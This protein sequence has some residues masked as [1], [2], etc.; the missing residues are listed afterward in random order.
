MSYH[1]LD[2]N[3]V[4]RFVRQN[5][6]VGVLVSVWFQSWSHR[7]NRGVRSDADWHG[8]VNV[9]SV[10]PAIA[11]ARLSRFKAPAPGAVI[12]SGLGR[13]LRIQGSIGIVPATRM[14]TVPLKMIH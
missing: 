5:A 10:R 9:S 6:T 14:R 13:A 3:A 4:S 8:A 7:I 1:P 11:A 2:L 12:P